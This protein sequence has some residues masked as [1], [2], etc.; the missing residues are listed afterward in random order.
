M[1]RSTI[2]KS[3]EY[4]ESVSIELSGAHRRKLAP[5]VYWDASVL[6]SQPEKISSFRLAGGRVGDQHSG[7]AC[8]DIYFPN[9]GFPLVPYA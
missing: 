7:D 4:P 2:Q 1:N 6:S 8:Y 9:L 3:T 5:R